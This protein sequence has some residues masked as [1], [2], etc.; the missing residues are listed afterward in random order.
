[1]PPL[2]EFGDADAWQ[3]GTPDLIVRFPAYTVPAVGPDLFGN[4]LTEMN[5]DE[6][7]YIKGDPDQ[8]GRRQVPSGRAPCAVL[9]GRAEPGG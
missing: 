6:D 2:P 7:R 3:I 8:G 1:M 5:L 4:M 9:R